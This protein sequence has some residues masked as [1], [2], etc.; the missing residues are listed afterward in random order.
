MLP[1]WLT[2]LSVAGTRHN[3]LWIP[4]NGHFSLSLCPTNVHTRT[5]R[6]HCAKPRISDEL[7]LRKK[8]QIQPKIWIKIL[9]HNSGG[10]DL[11]RSVN[12][13]SATAPLL[14]ALLLSLAP[15]PFSLSHSLPLSNFGQLFHTVKKGESSFNF[16]NNASLSASAMSEWLAQQKLSLLWWQ[17]HMVSVCTSKH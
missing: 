16:A 4:S 11:T 3:A 7:S 1:D 10:C 8:P 13:L 12:W 9:I 5:I 14:I 6:Q 15:S 2:A 17:A